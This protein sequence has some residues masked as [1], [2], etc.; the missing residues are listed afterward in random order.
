MMPLKTG[1]ELT[2][3]IRQQWSAKELPIILISGALDA[4]MEWNALR[5][6]ANECLRKPAERAKLVETVKRVMETGYQREPDPTRIIYRT[7]EWDQGKTHY[8]YCPEINQRTQGA[9]RER[10]IEDMEGLIR[11]FTRR[12][13]WPDHIS[14]TTTQENRMVL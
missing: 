11:A 9:T 4:A 12:E 14:Q 7:L 1:I 5:T 2:A 8:A 6:G 10:A 13:G 3:D